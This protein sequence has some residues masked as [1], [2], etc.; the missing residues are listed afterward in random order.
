MSWVA[1]VVGTVQSVDTTLL[2]PAFI[3]SIVCVK[4]ICGPSE[5]SWNFT[6]TLSMDRSPLLCMVALIF[7]ISPGAG[8][9]SD[10]AM[11]G[12][13]ISRSLKMWWRSR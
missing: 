9:A 7:T 6:L 10:R 5:P 13:V 4:P 8:L 2:S 12:L 3:V 1:G 11:S